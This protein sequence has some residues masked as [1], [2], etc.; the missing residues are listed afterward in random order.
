MGKPV[1]HMGGKFSPP[2]DAEEI[3]GSMRKGLY[4]FVMYPL[5]PAAVHLQV[6]RFG[7][8]H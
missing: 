6:S 4:L 8:H 3:K 7:V 2:Q 1:T 5:R